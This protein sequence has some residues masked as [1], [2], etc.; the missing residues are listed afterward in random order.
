MGFLPPDATLLI[1]GGVL[2]LLGRAAGAGGNVTIPSAATRAHCPMTCGDITFDYPFG[3]GAG[4]FR[5]PD[6]ELICNYTTQPPRLFL[7]DGDTEVVHS[8]DLSDLLNDGDKEIVHSI[9]PSDRTNNDPGTHIK[10]SLTTNLY[11]IV[12]NRYVVSLK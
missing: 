8:I 9:D 5:D 11:T 2:L 10:G 6:F 1:I 3:I 12:F 7:N 4:C